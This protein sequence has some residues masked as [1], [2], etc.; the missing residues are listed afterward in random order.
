MAYGNVS[1]AVTA[2]VIRAAN[3]KRTYLIIYN[4]G[5]ANVFVGDDASVTTSNGFPL[6]ST[7]SWIEMT[8]KGAVYGIVASGT[9]DVRWLERE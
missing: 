2:T 7:G 3:E 9:V 1:V 6:I 4:N 8:Y 5:T